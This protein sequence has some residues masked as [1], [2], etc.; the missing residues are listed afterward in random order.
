[1][2][3]FFA[4]INVKGTHGA[5]YAIA[6]NADVI[7]R[8]LVVNRGDVFSIKGL[9]YLEVNDFYIRTAYSQ[10]VEERYI[11]FETREL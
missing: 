7:S 8:L 11:Y 3:K 6:V 5:I 2:V 9:G 1:M 4:Y 10:G